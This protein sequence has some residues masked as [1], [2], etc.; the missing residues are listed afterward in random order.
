MGRACC[1]DGST[2]V[3]RWSR[4]ASLRRQHLNKDLKEVRDKAMQKPRGKTSQTK[5]TANAKA[6]RWEPV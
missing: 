6:L 3:N 5:G 4:Q 1:R 2:I